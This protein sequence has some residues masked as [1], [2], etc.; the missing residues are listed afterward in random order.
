M[1]YS[2]E[3]AHRRLYKLASRVLE[4]SNPCGGCPVK[5]AKCSTLSRERHYSK[6]W[7]CSGCKYSSENGCTVEAL[8]CKLYLCY[9]GPSKHA[10][11]YVRKRLH[12]LQLIA[13]EYNVWYARASA[14]DVLSLNSREDFWVFYYERKEYI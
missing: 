6:E 7:C 9:G 4:R 13:D 8:G 1:K 11:N 3:E 10:S 2:R 12:T 5:K 14:E